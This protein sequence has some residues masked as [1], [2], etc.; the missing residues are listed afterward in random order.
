MYG[1]QQRQAWGPIRFMAIQHLA[2]PQPPGLRPSRRASDEQSLV[3]VAAAVPAAAAEELQGLLPGVI[4]RLVGPAHVTDLSVLAESTVAITL[5]VD[6]DG[7][8]A[9]PGL[10]AAMEA[11][12]AA[13]LRA[14]GHL[15]ASVAVL[16][17]GPPL[18]S[19]ARSSRLWH[20]RLDE[21]RA[22][23][24]R[25]AD[26]S[27][28][29]REVALILERGEIRTVYQGIVSATGHRIVGYEALSRGPESHPWERPDLLLDA[30]A[31]AGLSGLVQWEM[32]RL[33]RLRASDRLPRG[34][35][36]LFLNSPD[37]SL[38]PE[39]PEDSEEEAAR[40]WPWHRVVAEVSER[41]PIVNCPAVWEV[42]D[43]GR[44][45]G[46][47]FALDDVGA[48]YAGL[49]SLA[50]LA[51]EFVKVD[52]ALVRHCDSDPS[53]QA[54][55]AALVQYAKLVGATVVA[56]G[57]ETEPES[58]VVCDLG[59]DLLQGFLYSRPTEHPSL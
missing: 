22:Q 29:R 25:R 41:S 13:A 39:S 46:L 42:R 24:Q 1:R 18:S 54:V 52:M 47:R 27:D 30:A 28:C 48:G 35:H 6:P 49:A 15:R 58:Q 4:A 19:H 21:L 40:A 38:W 57:I 50:L 59:V 14:A 34:Q 53:K 5:H 43:R 3:L 16:C 44:A 7:R 17:A 2:P 23:A 56:E 33:G 9:D 51:P 45:R 36:L 31:R 20:A 11:A 55:I 10:V 8:V 12:L 37:T 32:L 26:D